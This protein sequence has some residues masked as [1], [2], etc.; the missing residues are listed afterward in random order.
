[1]A[2]SALTTGKPFCNK[3]KEEARLIKEVPVTVGVGGF[4]EGPHPPPSSGGAWSSLLVLSV[5]Q[6][7]TG[8]PSGLEG[9]ACP[10]TR[11]GGKA[12][13]LPLLLPLLLLASLQAGHWAQRNPEPLFEMKQPRNLSAPEGGSIHIPFSFSY[14]GKLAKDPNVR[15]SWRWKHFHGEYIYNMTPPFIH[16]NFK[17]RLFLNWTE[18][19]K[20]GSLRIS[21]LRRED[22]SVYFCQVALDTLAYGKQR[23]Q[24]IEGTKLT[25]TPATKTTTW[26]P[27]TTTTTAGLGG[28]EGKRSSKLWSLTMEA[29]VGLALAS[30]VLLK[31]PIVGLAVYLWW[32]RSKECGAREQKLR[33]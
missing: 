7:P 4:G 31:I 13:G 33:P 18:R 12:M 21:D 16:E 30:V 5:P 8:L 2:P 22:Q 11:E 32:K 6:A 29:T 24:S 14:P 27:I 20:T 3:G 26:G 25:V 19:E 28:S 15:I 1:M 23:W 10:L 9:S 17:N